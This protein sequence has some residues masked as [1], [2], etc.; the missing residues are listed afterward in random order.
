MINIL[1]SVPFLILLFLFYYIVGSA[2]LKLSKQEKSYD[3]KIITGWII[4]FFIGWIIGIPNQLLGTAWAYFKWELLIACVILIFISVKFILKINFTSKLNKVK[5]K[6]ALLLHLKN[7]W[8]VYIVA[9][10]FSVYSIFNMQPYTINNYGDDYY[11]VKI[12][13]LLHS[14]H[15]LN[16]NYAYG[17]LLP[18]TSR[19]EFIRMQGHRI[20]NTYE[21]VYSVL[22]S[23][24]LLSIVPFVRI[25]M[26]MHN[27]LIC[28]LVYKKF[29]ELFLDKRNA[30]FVLLFFCFLLIPAGYAAKGGLPLTIRIFENWRNQTAIYMGSSIVRLCFFPMI[31][32]LI[33]QVL[34]SKNKFYI[35][36]ICIFCLT[37]IS[38]QSTAIPYLL[39]S[40][41]IFLLIYIFKSIIRVMK[42]NHIE[43]KKIY[44]VILLNV[45]LVAII[46]ISR[47]DNLILSLNVNIPAKF[48]VFSHQIVNS[49]FL[50]TLSKLYQPYYNDLFLL[51]TFS[52]YASIPLLLIACLSKKVSSK[53]VAIVAFLI[54]I[55]FKANMSKA[56]LALISFEFYGITRMLSSIMLLMIA[57]Y[58]IALIKILEKIRVKNI[59]I[60]ILSLCVLFGNVIF[61]NTH[62]Q[63]AE[64]FTVD[65]DA[66][67]K[68]GY[69]VKV[70]ENTQMIPTPFVDVANYF[71]KLPDRQYAVFCEP[72]IE[73][74][75]IQYS[76]MN[77]LLASDKIYS[78]AYSTEYKNKAENEKRNLMNN[79]YWY[80]TDYFTDQYTAGY[81][82]RYSWVDPNLKKAGLKYILTARKDFVSDLKKYGWK[83]KVG[84]NKKGYWL[85]KLSY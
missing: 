52:K 11:L 84:N 73:I 27:Y 59:S 76:S 3:D 32:Y 21:L 45:I 48:N 33:C 68:Q 8:F 64:K 56:F 29:A 77:L 60:Y 72:K 55:M 54:F 6:E 49:Y 53:I 26:T 17:N 61:I 14:S 38:F 65:G 1:K 74:K 43:G 28:F 36:C 62:L 46:L 69:S 7:Y 51:D 30:Q 16:Q 4:F 44:N 19:V 25:T 39:L 66:I 34:W 13:R 83:V 22:G 9:L 81:Y 67:V 20:F 57:F 10:A 2:F 42:N 63:N 15:I 23:I 12:S 70:F 85:L 50:K 47:L 80:L 82:K 40:L 35:I 18:S 79:A 5:I 37:M 75:G 78:P 71:E 31:I 24:S 58:G 41:I